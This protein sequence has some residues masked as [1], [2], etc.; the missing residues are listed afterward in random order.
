MKG[1]VLSKI[2]DKQDDFNFEIV[3]LPF[4]DGDIARSP[5]CGVCISQNS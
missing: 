4:L 5:T 2:Y 3:N 1:I